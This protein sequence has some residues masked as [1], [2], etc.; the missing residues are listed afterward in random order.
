MKSS[1]GFTLPNPTFLST[2]SEA[3]LEFSEKLFFYEVGLLIARPSPFCFLSLESARNWQL[4]TRRSWFL[5]WPPF[6]CTYSN[7]LIGKTVDIKVKVKFS[8][9]RPGLARR[10]GRGIALL[11]HDRGTRRGWVVIST[12]R[13]QF[14]PGKD[15]IPILQ[16]AGWTPGPVWTGGK[17]LPHRHSISDRPARSQSLDRLSYPETVDIGSDKHRATNIMGQ[18]KIRTKTPIPQKSFAYA[19]PNLG[20]WYLQYIYIYIYI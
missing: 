10:V 19:I 14:N 4:R 12:P 17:S 16:E 8:R 11:F 18:T 20:H 13:P 5:I 1:T 6:M 3:F 2:L 15:P 9:Y 7:S